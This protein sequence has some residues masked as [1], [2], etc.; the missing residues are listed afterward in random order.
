MVSKKWCPSFGE[1]SFLQL[2]PLEHLENASNMTL[3]CSV[4]L[5][6]PGSGAELSHLPCG[7][8]AWWE[9]RSFG[10]SETMTSC[11]G[12]LTGFEI[13]APLWQTWV[14]WDS[15][16][17]SE[18]ARS[19][20]WNMNSSLTSLLHVEASLHH[21]FSAP[22]WKVGLLSSCLLNPGSSSGGDPFSAFPPYCPRLWKCWSLLSL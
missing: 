18:W 10:G 15:S 16:C 17:C 19:L 14:G 8:R 13:L 11:S 2:F 5:S 3:R 22:R 1:H 4:A 7:S 6:V 21:L 12:F 20:E 9:A